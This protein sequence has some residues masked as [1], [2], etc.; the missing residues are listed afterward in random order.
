M[1]LQDLRRLDIETD[2]SEYRVSIKF[3][4]L[5]Q[6]FTDRDR[7]MVLYSKVHYGT[8]DF[9]WEAVLPTVRIPY[10][11]PALGF[12][13]RGVVFSSVGIYQ[14]APG[15]VQSKD[16]KAPV[17]FEDRIDIVTSRNSTL[18]VC[19]RRNG[20][21]IDFRRGN[22]DRYVPIGVFLKA[23]SGLP[24]DMLL[25]R[26]AFKPQ[27]LRNSFPCKVPQKAVD[28]AK[29]DTYG[30]DSDEEPKI[31][32]CVDMVYEA[33]MQNEIR[34]QSTT[35]SAHWKTNRIRAY[36]AGLHFKS[37]QNYE[38]N[39][40]LHARAI[41]SYLD[42]D[43][44]LRIY[45]EDGRETVFS[46]PRGT[47]INEEVA[48][49]LRWYDVSTLRVR[50]DR[51]FLLQ[52]DTPMLFRALG[53]KLVSDISSLGLS[54]GDVITKDT[55]KKINASD[56]KMLEVFT[57][58]GR[59]VL[60][61]SGGDPE[62][63]DFY[64]ILNAL[65][66][67]PFTGR[68]D[69]SQYEVANRIVVD[70]DKQVYLEVEQTYQNIIDSLVGCTQLKNIIENLPRL[71]STALENH[72]RDGST[73]ELAQAEI[74]N[75]MSRAV[76]ERR[77]SAL[78][79]STP[80]EMT[81]VQRDQYGRIDSLHSPESDKV[82][83]VQETT[84]MSRINPE[85]GEIEAPYEKV[86][87]GKPTG[88]VEYISATKE[89][90][91]YI[92]GWDDNLEDPVVM[93][94]HNGD[95]TTVVRERVD[96]RD[97][98]PF[99]DMSVSRMTI[100]FPEFS[101]PRRSLMATKMSGQAVPLLF[102]QRPRVSTGAD[103]EIPC[104]YY[105]GRQV[106]SSGL[107]EPAIAEC[108][109]G[110]MEI[111]SVKWTKV[112]AM[113]TCIFNGRSF[114]FSAPFTATDKETLYNYN[115]NCSE[116]NT[117]GLDDIV[118]YNQ[119]C[120]IGQHEYFERVAQG[121][122]P[123][124]KHLGKPA[125]AL[126]TNLKVM[127]KTYASSTVDDAVVISDRLV[128]N[129]TLSS[130]Q[131]FKYSYTLKVGET[132]R[133][134]EP[135]ARLH[136]HVYTGEPVINILRAKTNGSIEKH[137][138]AKQ[139]GEV[140]VSEV[141]TI[142]GATTANVWV[143]TLHDAAVGDK[144]A[145]RYGNKSVIAKI[146][147]AEDMPYDP[148]TG[149]TADIICSPLGIPSRM[150]F[151]QVVEVAL[152]AVMTKEDKYA[153]VTP[154]YPNIKKEVEDLYKSAG[155]QMKRLYNPV[156]GKYTERPV[157]IGTMYFLKL[158][159]MSNLKWSAV[160]YPT[161]VDPVF[162]QPVTSTNTNKGQSMEEMITWALA[163]AGS[164]QIL[165][166]FFT[167]YS[168]D[169]ASRK[170][171]F[172]MLNGNADNGNGTWDEN[173]SD[174][175]RYQP[176]NKDALV[177]Q[178]ILRMFGQDMVVSGGD[179][180]QFVPLNMDDILVEATPLDLRNHTENVS[181]SEWCKVK[182]QAPVVC[183]FWIENFPLNIVLGVK[184]V[185]TLANRTYYL[186]VYDR[187]I[188]SAKSLTDDRKA[189]LITGIEAVIALLENTTVDQAIAR[190]VNNSK[191]A[192]T[193]RDSAAFDSVENEEGKVETVEVLQG[194]VVDS[195]DDFNNGLDVSFEVADI[196]RFLYRM[197]ENNLELKDLVWYY[198]PILPKVFRQT[199]MLKGVESEHSF[200]KQLRH[201]CE[202]AKSSDIYDALRQFIGYGQ[203]KNDDLVSLRGYFFGKGSQSG[204]HGTVRGNVLSKRVGFSGRAVIVPSQ[205]IKM[206][207]YFIGIPW[208]M[209]M[210]EMSRVLS[211]RLKKRVSE[212]SRELSTEISLP[213][214]ALE[215]LRGNEWEDII[216]SL[217][218]F[219][220]Y[221]F[222]KYFTAL[223]HSDCL[224][225]YNYLREVVRDICEGN[226]SEDG[227]VRIKGK[228]MRPEEVP[229]DTTIDA[230]IVEVGRQPTLHK[231]STRCFFGRLVDG[232][233]K[234][235][236]PIVC[237]GFNADFDGDTMWHVQLMGEMK[238]EGWRTIS[239]LQDLISEKDGSYTLGLVQDTA[240]G[241]YCATIFKNNAKDFVGV[242]NRYYYFDSAEALRM[243]LEYGDLN[244]YD[245]VVF[246]SEGGDLYISTA[247]R[248]LVNCLVP[249]ALTKVPF[250]DK[251]GICRQVLGEEAI[252][253]FCQLK[254]DTVW[255]ATGIRPEDREDGV[256]IEKVL[257]DVYDSYGA[258]TSVDTA[259]SLYEVGLTAS[260]IYSVSAS[261]DDMA[262][263]VD[264]EKFMDEPRAYVAKL[265]TLEQMGLISERERKDASVNAWERA[266]KLAMGAVVKA[267][268]ENSNTHFM[269]YSGAR[270]KPDQVMQSVGFIGTISKTAQSDIEYPILRGYG[271]GLTSL[272]LTQ[273]RYT[274]RIGV[275]STQTGTKDTGYATRQTVYM[276]SGMG[277]KEED[278]GIEWRVG[279]VKYSADAADIV[280]DDG[281]VE[282]MS[283]LL[284]KFI[285]PASEHMGSVARALVR[286]GYMITEDSLSTIFNMGLDKIDLLGE[287]VTVRYHLDPEWK[288]QVLQYGYSYALPYTVGRKV[289]EESLDWVEKHG[290]REIVLFDERDNCDDLCFDREAYLPVDYDQSKYQLFYNGHKVSEELL[291]GRTVN[292]DSESYHYYSRL[293]EGDGTLTVKALQYLTKKRVRSIQFENGAVVTVRYSLSPLFKELVL[294]RASMG[295]PYLDMDGAITEAT[296]NEVELCQLDYIPVRTTLTCLSENGVCKWCRGKSLSTKAYANVGDNLGIA[297]AQAQCEPLSQATLNVTHSG[298][299]RGAGTGLVSG[300][301]YYM[302]MLKGSF[303]SDKMEEFA[304]DSGYIRKNPHDD[305]FFQIVS[306][307][308]AVLQSCELD[309]P[310]RLNV[311]DGAF[312]N[313][314]DT[315][316]TGLPQLNRYST[317]DIF[318]SALKTRY[319]LLQEYYRIFKALNVSPRNYE[320]LVREQTSICYLAEQASLPP[321]RDTSEEIRKGTGK[322]ELRVAKQSE[323][324]NKYSGVA[325]FAF[326]NVAEM[327]VSGVLNADGL[328]L[329]SILGNLVTGTKVGSAEAKFIPKRFGRVSSRYRKSAVRVFED[330]A[331]SLMGTGFTGAKELK[332]GEAQTLADVHNMADNLLSS[333]LSINKELEGEDT[334]VVHR[335][336]LGDSSTAAPVIKEDSQD[337]SGNIM[338]FASFE[339]EA[340]ESTPPVEIVEVEAISSEESDLPR[341]SG[342]VGRMNL[343]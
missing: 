33:L 92:V 36:F 11:D 224:F 145:G 62:V 323:V 250:E 279:D 114:V 310:D 3:D 91:K 37:E 290:L 117:Y 70:Y 258:R 212:M 142:D 210:I 111:V 53:Y 135:T 30:I 213:N 171:Y 299:K 188:T 121:T 314:G 277:V 81:A 57:P 265:N 54:A 292:P 123:L 209:A 227:L 207:P 89:N 211:I 243:Q 163:A 184:S 128:A 64:T 97:V 236:H 130:V 252:G 95:V 35:Y 291:Y 198:M 67:A 110:R 222:H 229:D 278:C 87:N 133:V 19:Y 176:D 191:V 109:N 154:F 23:F 263:D 257:L 58:E 85:T 331:A 319:L 233:S 47:F 31:E 63:G 107:G 77:A 149:E 266:R 136:N 22:N 108:P 327:I 18:R 249:G 21:H 152:G 232:Y 61:R 182:L 79:P 316:I 315:I 127:Y 32:E 41:G 51:S 131:I 93:A 101:Q 284:G 328:A 122:L 84:A 237:S 115:L 336:E 324:V 6:E 73:K 146:I 72:L 239:V 223:D 40:S 178:T 49:Q 116:D 164:K 88:Q 10:R 335:M 206:A 174:A 34:S 204:Q 9:D 159:Q 197:K 141:V 221:I 29:V 20:V 65:F 287:T 293:L 172:E 267:I 129:R 83:A 297:A 217:G 303:T 151:G 193:V 74:T 199:T 60:A 234:V 38:S 238:N 52:E 175:L 94:R 326:E 272:D 69:A 343:D 55:L 228:W 286:T 190:L 5:E 165:N 311:P 173:T 280:H 132:F 4:R 71:P 180:F 259:Q 140:I 300:L 17:G 340:D 218:E 283:S 46:L 194:E 138:Y 289:T 75:I 195:A 201:I 337:S 78:I 189:A 68:N 304:Q 24:Y 8:K 155:L 112:F 196:V 261:M 341:N 124:I 186:N 241:L 270:G 156:Y 126:G 39:L 14:R 105:T 2:D 139:A 157:M 179:K 147:P 100:P 48:E 298:G 308:G 219:N 143:A 166:N 282:P 255:L 251:W 28:L 27:V 45:D 103:T 160:G 285:D 162:G 118:F 317:R 177:T 169:E 80:A 320:I 339:E 104:L 170:R 334:G 242:R 301:K 113:Y 86:V 329:N 306:A 205:D 50:T 144:V 185:K 322:Y 244:Y 260:D 1:E 230:M 307:D 148:E 187:S 183:P 202:C 273:T 256:K 137:M 44:S 269:M 25:K 253:S 215:S 200:Q 342:E 302:K 333:L 305:H 150:N 295:L 248:V 158:E 134:Y 271:S 125:M 168:S 225:L 82:G 321:M 15:V 192:D 153:V 275:V 90:G 214:G 276:S 246:R 16:Q 312:V 12:M 226:V 264:V 181:E 42:K 7:V 66:T 294:G 208:R 120:D 56:I 325:G 309:D 313:K 296:L 268:P 216:C 247:G 161:A 102:P 98:S 203:V 240:L 13:L 281:S 262:V 274:A 330:K 106:V 99:C 231:K 288:A 220:P 245:V 332:Q 96:Y 59:K 43:L 167:L 235:I 318:Q 26:F 338:E 254:Y 119:S 76:A